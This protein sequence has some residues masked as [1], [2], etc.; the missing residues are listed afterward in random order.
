MRG[1]TVR[2]ALR[3]APLLFLCM[4]TWK[5]GAPISEKGA[6]ST[7]SGS[8]AVVGAACKADWACASGVCIEATGDSGASGW[9]GGM[10]T[11]F[12]PDG[13]CPEGSSCRLLDGQRYCLPTC[14]AGGACRNGYVCNPA[15]AQCL[16]DCRD[17]W[18]CATG[19]TCGNDGIC[20][21]DA[22]PPLP[23]GAACAADWECATGVC[24]PA[25]D[26][27]STGWPGGLCTAFC[28]D[29]TCP[30]GS[31]CFMAGLQRVCV[32]SCADSTS[33]RQGYACYPGLRQCLPD[34][35]AGF[36]CRP[37]THCAPDGA[38]VPGP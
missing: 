15:I 4:C 26:G 8:G 3:I 35:R 30:Q 29:G 12:C 38:C 14:G 17:G 24:L 31:S 34:C 9:T 20:A 2:L 21:L 19:Y 22:P 7:A 13:A 1:A 5:T 6:S 33:C 25:G 27:G 28:P 37:G 11:A 16:P 10:C 23:L 36:S 32:A 18:S